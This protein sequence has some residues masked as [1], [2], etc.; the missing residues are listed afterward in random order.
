MNGP[1]TEAKLHRPEPPTS[2]QAG[3]M[4]E[5][6]E[7][8][9][10]TAVSVD[11][12]LAYAPC[13]KITPPLARQVTVV[14]PAVPKAEEEPVALGGETGLSLMPTGT[15]ESGASSL[16]GLSS[17][18]IGDEGALVVSLEGRPHQKRT[19]TRQKRS[20]KNAPP[21]AITIHQ[22]ELDSSSAIVQDSS[23]THLFIRWACSVGLLM[24]GCIH[25]LAVETVSPTLLTVLYST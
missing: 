13:D 23:I 24:T 1:M 18:D 2:S 17:H 12:T 4:E 6:E 19:P 14:Q 7:E 3:L 15:L 5:E 16:G 11:D 22:L 8:E 9:D 21:M 20:A 25:H 10:L